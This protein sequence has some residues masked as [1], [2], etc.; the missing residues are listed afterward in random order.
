MY[1]T[2][3]S[4]LGR[5]IQFARLLEF[6]TAFSKQLF[7]S[8]VAM[9][10]L[11]RDGANMAYLRDKSNGSYNLAQDIHLDNIDLVYHPYTIR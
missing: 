10:F 7:Q 5:W 2:E 4:G 1:Q 8:W 6:T 3:E 11:D 9:T